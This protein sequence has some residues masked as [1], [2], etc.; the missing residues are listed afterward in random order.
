VR[1]TRPASSVAAFWAEDALMGDKLVYA[2]L[3]IYDTL[4]WIG[5]RQYEGGDDDTHSVGISDGIAQ[6][7]SELDRLLANGKIFQKCVFTTHGNDG[8]IFFNHQQIIG[9]EL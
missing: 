1:L 2:R 7:K 3:R 6:F 8:A 9:Y 5:R 4:A